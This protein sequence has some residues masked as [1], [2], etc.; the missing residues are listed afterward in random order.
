LKGVS[1]RWWK[2]EKE[3]WST[4]ISSV[5]HWSGAGERI[6]SIEVRIHAS[7]GIWNDGEEEETGKPPF[8]KGKGRYWSQNGMSRNGTRRHTAV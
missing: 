1:P 8:C 6:A 4:K 5:R 7:R 2:Q 3:I